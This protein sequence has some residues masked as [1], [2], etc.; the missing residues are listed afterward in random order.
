MV[1]SVHLLGI[2]LPQ[3]LPHDPTAAQL[4]RR[5]S[6]ASAESETQ[7]VMREKKDGKHG[8]HG[9]VS[10]FLGV[11]RGVG[12]LV[13]KRLYFYRIACNHGRFTDP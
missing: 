1:S 7:R 9:K 13:V 6:E 2:S 3:A 12:I 11:L 10:G 4:A 8:F 5:P